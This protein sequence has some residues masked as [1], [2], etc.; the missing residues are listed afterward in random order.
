MKKSRVLLLVAIVL[1]IVLT[2]FA[3]SKYT[4]PPKPCAG[5]Q[6]WDGKACVTKVNTSVGLD[7]T[8]SFGVHC[9][10]GFCEVDGKFANTYSANQKKW[11]TD[12]QG[13]TG[14]CVKT[15]PKEA[16]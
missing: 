8:C 2:Y 3:S 13:K 6:F 11:E 15:K 12:L 7:G 5:D 10:P 1:F 9:D 16:Y 4:S 14:K